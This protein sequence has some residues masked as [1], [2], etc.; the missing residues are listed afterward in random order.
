M[1]SNNEYNSDSIHCTSSYADSYADPYADPYVDPYADP[2][3]DPYANS[4]AEPQNNED[5]LHNTA[6]RRKAIDENEEEKN[7]KK[8]RVNITDPVNKKGCV[9]SYVWDYFQIEKGR[10]ICKIIILKKGKEEECGT[11]YK[12]DTGTGNMKLHLR[13]KHGILGPDDLEQNL[14]KKHQLRIDQM[15]RKVMPHRETIQAELR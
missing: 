1:D 6:A 9:K 13:V 4:D 14:D 3:T 5:E 15:V 8:I 7:V 12:Y 11:N 2:Y 10:A